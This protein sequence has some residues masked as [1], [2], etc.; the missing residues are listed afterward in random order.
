MA[1]KKAARGTA[2]ELAA[3]FPGQRQ[4]TVRVKRVLGEGDARVV[5]WLSHTIAVEPMVIEQLGR[6]A[7]RLLPITDALERTPNF[8][9]LA[10]SHPDVIIGVV[11]EAID[12]PIEQARMIHGAD[13]V[14]LTR[15]ILEDNKDF[16]DRLL[17]P[18]VSGMLATIREAIVGDGPTPS[19]SSSATDTSVPSATH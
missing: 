18:L 9:A 3:M 17:G 2:A 16:F 10:V 19:V 11:A 13:F 12:W 5:E 1:Q 14:T 6:V 4:I 7:E 8:L 15:A